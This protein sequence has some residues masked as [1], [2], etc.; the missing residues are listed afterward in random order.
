MRELLLAVA[1]DQR[2]HELQLGDDELGIV[3]DV[4]LV[5]DESPGDDIES[6]EGDFWEFEVGGVGE[7]LGL[8]VGVVEE[9]EQLVEDVL[10]EE[11]HVLQRELDPDVCQPVDQV[12]HLEADG[13]V[14][15]G[16]DAREQLDRAHELLLCVDIRQA[17]ADE[18]QSLLFGPPVL[19]LTKLPHP[20]G[21]EAEVGLNAH[22]ELVLQ[23]QQLKGARIGTDG[24]LIGVLQL[25]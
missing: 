23:R 4:V 10:H 25:F 20:L 21:N 24:H 22:A 14:L 11:G 2:A 6:Q 1:L 17:F 19:A 13:C 15:G 8:A 3:F 16:Y 18:A 5:L 7:F 12:D 9:V